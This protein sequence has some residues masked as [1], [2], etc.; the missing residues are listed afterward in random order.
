MPLSDD[1]KAGL[2]EVF[3]RKTRSSQ[4]RLSFNTNCDWYCP[5]CNAPMI[6]NDGSVICPDCGGLLNDFV[7]RL[8]EFH[9]HRD[10][11]GNWT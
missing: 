6:A 4:R 8:I 5:G 10:A 9:P 7:Y 11:H 1:M 3:I 2:I